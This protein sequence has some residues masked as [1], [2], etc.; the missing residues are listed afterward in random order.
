V[1]EFGTPYEIIYED[2]RSKDEGFYEKKGLL[3]VTAHSQRFWT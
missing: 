2:L 1:Y 3:Q